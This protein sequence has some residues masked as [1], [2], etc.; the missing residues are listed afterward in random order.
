[1]SLCRT[2]SSYTCVPNL[3]L[4]CKCSYFLISWKKMN[5][6]FC[7]YNLF[8]KQFS[9]QMT[10]YLFLWSSR[11]KKILSYFW[12]MISPFCSLLRATSRVENHVSI[13]IFCTYQIIWFEIV[14]YLRNNLL[15][16]FWKKK[17]LPFS[18]DRQ[19]TANRN[20]AEKNELKKKCAY[21][22]YCSTSMTH[23]CLNYLRTHAFNCFYYTFEICEKCFSIKAIH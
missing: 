21:H 9:I 4:E 16:C 13:F 23:G 5:L 1:M 12:L 3:Y 20:K 22:L 17:L 19:K 18:G 2:L 6:L 11:K 10:W 8:N 7:D 14:L 15:P